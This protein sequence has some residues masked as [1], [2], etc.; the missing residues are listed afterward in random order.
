MLRRITEKEM[1][2]AIKGSYGIVLDVQKRLEMIKG[3]VVPYITVSKY[4]HKWA[5]TEQAVEM[6]KDRFLDMAEKA[7]LRPEKLKNSKG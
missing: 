4:I 3:E 5:S 1:L 2:E 6:E 7:L